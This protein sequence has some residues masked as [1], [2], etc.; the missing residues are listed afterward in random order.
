MNYPTQYG[1]VVM[2]SVK[3]V[4]K[5]RPV[6]DLLMTFH[7]VSA[8]RSNSVVPDHCIS[9]HVRLT[10]SGVGEVFY[11]SI[12][13]QR[14]LCRKWSKNLSQWPAS[15]AYHRGSSPRLCPPTRLSWGSVAHTRIN[16]EIRS[17]TVWR[18]P[19]QLGD[20]LRPEC[21]F[22]LLRGIRRRTETSTI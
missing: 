13:I 1:G 7:H 5:R 3:N 4:W 21:S 8:R 22:N 16:R 18:S 9:P 2:R 10:N 12:R 15:R 17:R 19:H 14:F 6:F 11:Y 20:V